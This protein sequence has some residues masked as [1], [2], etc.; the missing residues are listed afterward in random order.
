MKTV[1]LVLSGC[2]VFDGS[3]ITEAAGVVIAL[4][5][6][7]L[8]V[9]FFAPNRGQAVVNHAAG[10]PMAETRNIMDEAARIARGQIQPLEAL[11]A[12]E[13]DAIVFPGG[14]GA[15]KNLTSFASDGANAKLFDDVKA[16]VLPF[17]L[18]HKPVV[19][20]C[21]APLVLG[22]IAKEAGI[23][24]A[25]ITFGHAAEGQ[26]M[27][28]ALEQWGQQHVETP[29]EQACVDRAHRFVS[30]PAYMYGAATPAQVF[31]SCQAAVAGLQSL[32]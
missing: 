29:V 26:S 31:A 12:A 22:L 32:L 9:R 30:A 5:Q 16:A 28:A 25:R 3:E 4:S 11:N 27:I 23:Q 10:R 21:A 6:A 18:A 20:L 7:G 14:F 17:V 15:A 8:A 13:F 2:G 24:G 19:A 1:A